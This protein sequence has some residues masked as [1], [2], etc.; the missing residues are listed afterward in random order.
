MT[1]GLDLVI[2][3]THI[4]AAREALDDAH[5]LLELAGADDPVLD[6]AASA[7]AALQVL[8]QR[9]ERVLRKAGAP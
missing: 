8:R 6:A 9:A 3:L 1:P 7:S 4:D 2:A 5:R